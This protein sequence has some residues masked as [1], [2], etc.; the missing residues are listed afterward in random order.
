MEIWKD[1]V[2]YEGLYQVSNLGRLKSPPKK[3]HKGCIMKPS[4]KKDGYVR[5]QLIKCSKYK[6]LYVHR[7]VAEAFLQHDSERN[8]V[9]H[10]DGN[11]SNN[12]LENLE[13]VTSKQN[14]EHSIKTGLRK[15]SGM[16]GRF[17]K[18]S[19]KSKSILQLSACGKVIR[20]WDSISDAARE[21]R[22]SPQS[23][24]SVL[25]GRKKSCKGYLWEYAD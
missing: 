7:I 3:G 25:S 22:C 19:P 1:V 5:I 23:I 24:C 15:S 8:E 6:T 14:I 12:K 13:W 10:I 16:K 11:K 18:L 4:I 17:G 2:G 20:K 21:L 9:N